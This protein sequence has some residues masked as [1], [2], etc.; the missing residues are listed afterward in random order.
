MS[1]A[2][3]AHLYEQHRGPVVVA[4]ARRCPWVAPV[5]RE[6]L[7]HD[8]YTAVL[9]RERIGTLEP[10][11]MH[12]RELRA[13]LVKSA[14]HKALDE[15]K[16]AERRLTVGSI[17]LAM[18]AR[19]AAQALDD[20][21]IRAFDAATVRELVDEL[22][23]RGQA[24]L[25]LRFLHE[26]EPTEIQS[27]LR[28]SRRA[29]R[30]ELERAVRQIASRYELVRSGRWHETRR[31]LVL[32]YVAGVSRAAP[33]G[34]MARQHLAACPDCAQRAVELRRAAERVRGGRAAA[35]SDARL[36]CRSSRSSRQ[37]QG[38]RAASASL[39]AARSGS[40][41]SL[42]HRVSDPTPL[43]GRSAGRPG[44]SHRWM[45]RARG[46]RH[47][48]RGRGAA[49]RRQRPLAVGEPHPSRADSKPAHERPAQ[50]LKE[51]AGITAQPDP[52][53]LEARRPPTEGPFG[54]FTHAVT[55][56][57]VPFSFRVPITDA[58]AGKRSLASRPKVRWRAD[59]I[60]K[61]MVGAQGAEAIIF[62][63]SFPDG[64]YADPC[65]RLCRARRLVH[66]PPI[67][68]PR[69]PRRPAPSR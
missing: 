28:I 4:L 8:A 38:Q 41:G 22:S 65:A 20:A 50:R 66:R 55:E 29:Y 60:S 16:S 18:T 61:S 46:R 17:S 15:R 69:W 51:D 53:S 43:R 33:D 11:R 32:A 42:A 68:P 26:L 39:A 34:R 2:A 40:F 62:W 9:E 27:L 7:Y 45:P 67:S 64:D 3:L 57:G 1:A 44:R 49:R 13:Y 24:V 12:P 23:A 54:S 47:L 6:S 63:T 14:I 56:E 31:S 59:S 48:L 19:M 10:E 37:L 21:A 5:D 58:L 52:V 36:R 25:R 30:K 35:R